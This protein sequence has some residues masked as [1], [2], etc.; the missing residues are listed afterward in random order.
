MDEPYRISLVAFC[1]GIILILTVLSVFIATHQESMPG[2][3]ITGS[4]SFNEK[5]G[6]LRR[7]LQKNRSVDIVIAGSSM[8][9]NNLDGEELAKIAGTRAILNLSSWGI[10]ISGSCQLLSALMDSIHPRLVILP[11]F[12]GDFRPERIRDID[13]PLFK[14]CVLG[15]N[16]PWLY[17]RN[18]DPIYY[19][20]TYRDQTSDLS[21]QRR[22]YSSLHF[23][24]FG[25][26]PFS[27]DHFQYDAQRWDSY[28][29]DAAVDFQIDPAALANLRA[30][31]ENLKSR[32]VAV[33]MVVCPMRKVAEEKLFPATESRLWGPVRAMVEGAGGHFVDV[34]D[35]NDF[36]DA[37]FV[38]SYHLNQN[39]ARKVA[40]CIAPYVR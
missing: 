39:G 18:L 2:P 3:R 15:G 21:L 36:N 20:N 32:G 10:N 29:D 4:V 24:A 22:S 37:L 19:Y 31:L 27:D 23:D 14:Q 34:G 28:R 33:M 17:L 12:F 8:G 9:V 40:D 13:L 11:V 7:A 1:G 25:G 35:R 30:T 6:W 16:L 26:V 5:A 38:D